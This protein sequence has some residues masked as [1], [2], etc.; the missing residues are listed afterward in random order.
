MNILQ[1]THTMLEILEHF[2]SS[3]TVTYANQNHQVKPNLPLVSMNVLSSGRGSFP[4]QRMQQDQNVSFYPSFLKIQVD[5]Y[6]RGG[7]LSLEGQTTPIME[8]TALNDLVEF[9]NFLGSHYFLEWCWEKN[10]TLLPVNQVMDTTHLLGT[11][12]FQFR[13]TMEVKL[14]FTDEVKGYTG[15]HPKKVPLPS[16]SGGGSMEL[17]TKELGFF[18]EVEIS[19]QI[20]NKGDHK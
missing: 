20:N 9:S 18:K 4:P 13:A 14:N 8:N 6:T 3:A 10:I 15:L 19:P 11:R 1:A 17:A 16:A 5:L 12:D 7:T 2:F